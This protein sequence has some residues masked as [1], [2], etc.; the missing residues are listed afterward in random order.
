[1]GEANTS[2]R[3][4]AVMI[5]RRS[6]CPRKGWDLFLFQMEKRRERAGKALKFIKVTKNPEDL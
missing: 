6:G 4:N 2:S 3:R 5:Y 1:M